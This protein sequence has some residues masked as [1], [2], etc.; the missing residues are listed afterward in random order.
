MKTC[1]LPE[2]PSPGASSFNVATL[3]DGLDILLTVAGCLLGLAAT[4]STSECLRALFLP[5][6]EDRCS[7]AATASTAALVAASST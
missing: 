5:V 1:W 3:L 2:K 6:A 4:S 7:D